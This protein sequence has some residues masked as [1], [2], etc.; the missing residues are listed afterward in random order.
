MKIAFDIELM[1]PGCAL[2]QAAMGGTEGIANYFDSRDWIIAPTK[3]M[4]IYEVDKAQLLQIVE[5]VKASI[6]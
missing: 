3:G 4:K 1:K 6:A 2:L 5:K